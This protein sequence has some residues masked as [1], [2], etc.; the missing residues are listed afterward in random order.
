MQTLSFLIGVIDSKL[1]NNKLIYI[2]QAN[3]GCIEKLT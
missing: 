2:I 3:L 1:K